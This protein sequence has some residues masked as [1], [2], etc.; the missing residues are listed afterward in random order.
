MFKIILGC[1]VFLI[2]CNAPGINQTVLTTDHAYYEI[3]RT[4]SPDKSKILL[5]YGIN[6]GAT[7]QGEVGT[8][9]LNL[10]DTSKNIWP[11]TIP[12][13]DYNDFKW[14]DN[15]TAIFYLDFLSKMRQDKFMRRNVDT[16][17]NGI[18]L[19]F[20]YKDLIDSFFQMNIL[21]DELSPNKQHRLL[22]YRYT[23]NQSNENF[24][25]ISVT[26]PGD[27]IPRYGNFFIS[28]IEN[29]YIYYCKWS[30]ENKL[31]LYTTNGG[32]A[33]IEN[34]MVKSRPEILIE[35]KESDDVVSPFRWNYKNFY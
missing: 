20:E 10:P 9:I 4:Y 34:Y 23:K 2:S 29:D 14:L 7:G 11:F 6:Q 3:K 25:N 26:M 19:N 27:S 13:Y 31:Q 28:D 17:I 12:F 24:L 35:I 18:N 16:I 32:Y 5:T 21:Q 1:Y 8:A 22:V 33:L 15:N 30:N